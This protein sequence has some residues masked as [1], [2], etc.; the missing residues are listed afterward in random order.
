M[1]KV[2]MTGFR[3]LKLTDVENETV[4]RGRRFGGSSEKGNKSQREVWKMRPSGKGQGRRASL[5]HLKKVRLGETSPAHAQ[6][7]CVEHPAGNFQ[8]RG[9]IF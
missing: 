8:T 5:L 6:R 2:I 3:R 1:F 7:G 4:Q 9:L